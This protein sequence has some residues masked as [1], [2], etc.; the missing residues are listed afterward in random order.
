ML[1]GNNKQDAI[2]LQKHI[3]FHRSQNQGKKNLSMFFHVQNNENK[4]GELQESRD[5]KQNCLPNMLVSSP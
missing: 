2:I 1:T 5:L 4:G 3:N